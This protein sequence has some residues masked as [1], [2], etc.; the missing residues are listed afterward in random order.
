VPRPAGLCLPRARSRVS[1]ELR[2]H[3]AAG[4][5]RWRQAADPPRISKSGSAPRSGPY[6]RLRAV[7]RLA[8]LI[9]QC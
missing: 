9:R 3:L 6:G 1:G 2:R 7:K 4:Q 8:R 5:R